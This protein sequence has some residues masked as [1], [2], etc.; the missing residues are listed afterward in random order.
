MG[1]TPTASNMGV[2]QNG[3]CSGL[4]IRGGNPDA[5]SIPAAPKIRVCGRVVMHFSYKEDDAGSIPAGRTKYG[6][7]AQLDE[8]RATNAEV[9]WFDPSQ[10][11][12]FIGSWRNA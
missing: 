12:Q 5:G 7:V 11:H 8:Q 6:A 10:S 4:L 2:W 9:C 3:L 1:S